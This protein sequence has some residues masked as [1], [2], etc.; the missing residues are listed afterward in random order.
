V[1]SSG[2]RA[3]PSGAEATFDSYAGSYEQALQRGVGL[4]GEDSA[5][6]ARARVAWVARLLAELAFEAR[7]VLDYGCGT[8]STT[9]LLLDL[10]GT[11]KVLGTD[12][13]TELLERARRE[14]ASE[15]IGFA[16]L[17]TP[18]KEANDLAYCN[19]VFHHIS[20]DGRGAA[21]EYLWRS[22]RAGGLFAFWENNPWNPGTRLVMRRIPFD[23]DA[24]TLSA[25]TARKLL[26]AGG[27]E[28]LR[29]DFLFVFPR[30]LS[31]LR[32]LESAM[33]KL[34]LGAQYLVLARKPQALR[35]PGERP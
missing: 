11:I 2:E 32:P 18:P 19:G 29:T 3:P 25:P 8:G 6:F 27:F 30:A 21:I 16:P 35:P 4:S 23:R 7:S 5:Y 31:P 14:H 10:P 20:P 15:A 34:P 1:T 17:A 13:S 28:I 24:I 12:L 9:P 26:T 22:L 33:A